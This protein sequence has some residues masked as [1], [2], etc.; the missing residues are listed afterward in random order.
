[1]QISIVGKKMLFDTEYLWTEFL[2]N[3]GKEEQRIVKL[4][5][6]PQGEPQLERLILK[7]GKLPAVEIHLHLWEVKT[8]ITKEVLFE[9]M[10]SG[11]HIIPF[12]R[13]LTPEIYQ[14]STTTYENLPVKFPGRKET[15]LQTLKILLKQ[16]ESKEPYGY[17]WYSDSIPLAG[18]VKLMLIEDKYHTMIFLSD[19]GS[20]AKSSISETPKKLDFRE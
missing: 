7:Y 19:Y 4:L 2:L 9:E 12:T 18:L 13:L 5:I 10:T 11:I 3:Q 15:T 16:P 6:S 17:I 8:R 14:D 1:M 20:D